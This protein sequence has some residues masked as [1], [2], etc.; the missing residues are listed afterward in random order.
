MRWALILPLF[1]AGCGLP[2]DPEKTSERIAA[3]HELRVGVTDNPPWVKAQSAEPSGIEAD[4]VR[5][6][7]RR[8]GAKVLWSRGSETMLMQSLKHHELDIVI[9]GFDKKTSWVSS[10]GLTQPWATDAQSKKRIMLAAP[11]E[12]RFI[13]S[14]DR[15][16][17][18]RSSGKP[19]S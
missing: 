13:L 6:F 4:L 17:V 18:E 1:V 7:G 12:N 15:F 16:L 9:G 19:L 3:T 10:A 14:L 8:L 5:D 2:H 11:G